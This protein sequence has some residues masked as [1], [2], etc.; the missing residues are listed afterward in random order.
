MYE[1]KLFKKEYP[2]AVAR[3]I[4]EQNGD[5]TF[6]YDIYNPSESKKKQ[7]KLDNWGVVE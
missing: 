4:A 6:D 1:S 7:Q 3:Y 2:K 5:K